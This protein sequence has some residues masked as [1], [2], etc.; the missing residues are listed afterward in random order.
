MWK[1]LCVRF[2]PFLSVA[3]LPSWQGG[4]S[5]PTP[6]AAPALRRKSSQAAFLEFTEFELG[7]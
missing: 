4:D 1:H 6:N 5:P 3:L 7:D 2:S